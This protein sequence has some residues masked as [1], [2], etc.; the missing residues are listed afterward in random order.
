[1]RWTAI[2]KI[3]GLCKLAFPGKKVWPDVPFRFS[4]EGDVP[5]FDRSSG[6]EIGSIHYSTLPHKMLFTVGGIF[7]EVSLEKT[8]S[9]SFS[10]SQTKLSEIAT[11]VKIG[12]TLS[13]NYDGEELLEKAEAA[14]QAEPHSLS[15]ESWV[16]VNEFPQ[17]MIMMAE[18]K[19][20]DRYQRVRIVDPTCMEHNEMGVILDIRGDRNKGFQYLILVDGSSK[21][22]WFNQNS[23]KFNLSGVIVNE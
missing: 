14:Y 12:A 6:K 8:P 2:K 16:A 9:L 5:V 15:F 17:E 20:Y 4:K 23:L 10:V 13:S 3:W 18:K 22:L 21:P 1:M 11:P 19:K 7:D